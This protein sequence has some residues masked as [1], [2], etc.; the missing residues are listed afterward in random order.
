MSKKLIYTLFIIM[1][2]RETVFKR[3]VDLLLTRQVGKLFRVAG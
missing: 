1:L 3:T 2:K